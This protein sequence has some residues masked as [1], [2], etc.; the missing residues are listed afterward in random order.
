MHPTLILDTE[1]LN[2]LDKSK[3]FD[4]QMFVLNVLISSLI[5][6]NSVGTIDEQAVQSLRYLLN[7]IP[8]ENPEPPI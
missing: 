7:F 2:G 6:Y 1:G 4:L 8:F 5:I 3:Q